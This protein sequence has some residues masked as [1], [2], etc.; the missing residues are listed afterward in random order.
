MVELKATLLSLVPNEVPDK[1]V[2]RGTI[3]IVKRN[4]RSIREVNSENSWYIEVMSLQLSNLGHHK[5]Y[6]V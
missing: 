4:M 1:L 2:V 3:S 6:I 5:G